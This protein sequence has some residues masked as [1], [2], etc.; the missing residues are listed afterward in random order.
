MKGYSITTKKDKQYMSEYLW[1][2]NWYK[3][4]FEE[5]KRNRKEKS[6]SLMERL[7]LYLISKKLFF[8]NHLIMKFNKIQI[9]LKWNLFWKKP[10]NIFKI[11][12]KNHKE[13]KKVDVYSSSSFD[14]K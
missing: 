14:S 11:K 12:I 13:K 6:H 3:I 7:M 4:D 2:R 9:D 5:W 8:Y 10:E 1:K